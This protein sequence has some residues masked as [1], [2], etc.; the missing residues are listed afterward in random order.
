MENNIDI[1][2]IQEWEEIIKSKF[3]GIKTASEANQYLEILHSAEGDITFRKKNMDTE[4]E[5][6]TANNILDLIDEHYQTVWDWL[7]QTPI[8]KK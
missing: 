7:K 8:V 4:E 2:V 5:K 1:Q 6:K 3:Q